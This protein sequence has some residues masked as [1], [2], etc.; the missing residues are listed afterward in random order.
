MKLVN[1]VAVLSIYITNC[2]TEKRNL[3][4]PAAVQSNAP[5]V[6]IEAPPLVRLIAVGTEINQHS[7]EYNGQPAYEIGDSYE[8]SRIVRNKVETM[9]CQVVDIGSRTEKGYDDRVPISITIE[10]RRCSVVSH[11][12]VKEGENDEK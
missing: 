2:S 4:T 9:R 10:T 5:Q 3:K 12:D 6:L 11:S 8:V 1:L 7:I